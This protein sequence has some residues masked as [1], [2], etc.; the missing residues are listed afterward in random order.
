ME[1]KALHQFKAENDFSK[2]YEKLEAFV[3]ELREFLAGSLH[4]AE[5]QGLLDRGYYDPEGMLDEVYLDAFNAFSDK[6]DTKTLRRFL[7]QTALKK[8]V[9]KE[10]EEVPDE[11]NT[12][13]LLKQ[14]L[15]A[16][17]EE[18]T[19]LGDGD[20]ILMEELED[21]SYT[22]KPGWSEEIRLH[23]ALEKL[24]IQ[25]FELHE[26]A[27]LSDEKRKL[28]GILYY[29]IPTRSK[30]VVELYT[31]GHQ[32]VHEISE[33]LEVPEAI[34]DRILFKVKERLKLL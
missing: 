13:A 28:L 17:S 10:E 24:L 25:K 8:M 30:I 34:I 29:L 2:F 20:P 3:P 19:T 7:F 22:Q 32:S 6:M 14:E 33:I 27:L 9:E 12:S 5:D 26:E 23:D 21:I 4:T 18:F 15:K 31:F 11:V 16:M 1:T